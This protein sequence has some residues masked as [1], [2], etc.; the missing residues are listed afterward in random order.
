MGG[1]QGRRQ[2]SI[3]GRRGTGR[4]A[5]PRPLQ[6]RAY[7]RECTRSIVEFVLE[8]G[9]GQPISPKILQSPTSRDFQHIFLFLIRFID[10]DFEFRKRFEDE[11]PDKLK[12]LGYPFTISKSAL[13][14]VGSPHTWPALLGALT[15]LL[16]CLQYDQRRALQNERGA[17][18]GVDDAVPL[19]TGTAEEKQ[20]SPLVVENVKAAYVNFLAGADDHPEL[21]REFRAVQESEVAEER[22]RLEVLPATIERKTE[23]LAAMKEQPP[24]LVKV[25]GENKKLDET[26]PKMRMFIPSLVEHKEVVVASVNRKA[27]EKDALEER[28]FG[29]GE[30]TAAL[31]EIIAQ[32]EANAIHVES[33]AKER[34]EIKVALSKLHEERAARDV[35]E[36]TSEN[37]LSKQTNIVTDGLRQYQRGAESLMFIPETAKNANGVDFRIELVDNEDGSQKLSLD[38]P[39]QVVPALRSLK[40][41]FY[42]RHASL[43]TEELDLKD[44]L[45]AREEHL[46]LVR[47]GRFKLETRLGKLNREYNEEKKSMEQRLRARKEDSREEELAL[48]RRKAEESLRDSA[49][50]VEMIVTQ[51]R[52][53]EQN[54]AAERTRLARKVLQH[55]ERVRGCNAAM[56]Q[57]TLRV[58]RH[59]AQEKVKAEDEGNT[60]QH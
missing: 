3:P 52:S 6:D 11:V 47:D 1:P 22:E 9:Y 31:K 39:D 14:A 8:N 55:V 48:R 25:R 54:T 2:S 16:E 41:S 44:G 37:D 51:L 13:S 43:Q 12:A 38:V 58:A 59:F 29:L 40:D 21:D 7:M 30:E 42:K 19:E 49:R 27:I 45:D 36:K 10:P 46:M 35:E 17:D 28:I 56:Q 18:A 24:P 33:I 15:W 5:D 26:I 23:T 20:F 34:A 50:T 60:T 4:R 32:Q 57:E 53:F